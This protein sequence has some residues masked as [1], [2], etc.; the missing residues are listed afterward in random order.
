MRQGVVPIG[1]LA[2]YVSLLMWGRGTA[3]VEVMDTVWCWCLL[4]PCL[5]NVVDAGVSSLQCTLGPVYIGQ[6]ITAGSRKEQH[7]RT[8]R[9]EPEM[10]PDD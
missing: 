1:V 8:H 4:G 9:T 6:V 3:R 10:P 5:G 2:R 7:H